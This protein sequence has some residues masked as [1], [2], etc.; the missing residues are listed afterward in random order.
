MDESI[1]N[2]NL[3]LNFLSPKVKETDKIKQT[4]YESSARN[5]NFRSSGPARRELIL[6]IVKTY[7]SPH[8]CGLTEIELFDE[9]G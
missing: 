3:N 1:T 6:K 5:L 9:S 8:I 4:S 2:K 7:G